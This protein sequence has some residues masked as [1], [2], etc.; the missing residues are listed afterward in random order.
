VPAPGKKTKADAVKRLLLV[1]LLLL[2]GCGGNRVDPPPHGEDDEVGAEAAGDSDSLAAWARRTRDLWAAGDSAGAGAARAAGVRRRVGAG[3]GRAR[4]GAGRDHERATARRPQGRPP[5]SAQVTDALTRVGLAVDIVESHGTPVV[6]QVLVSDPVGSAER[7]HRVLGVARSARILGGGA[8]P[9]EGGAGTRALRA[10]RGG[11]PGE[12]CPRRRRRR[13]GR[14][15][16]R[17]RARAAGSRS[18][19][20]PASAAIPST[21]A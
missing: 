5:S 7:A 1:A 13:A 20:R 12:S 21:S 2:P 4:L 15:R 9:A 19:S 11:R 6:W 10:G 14:R 18:R 3:R 8:G 16:G 17:G